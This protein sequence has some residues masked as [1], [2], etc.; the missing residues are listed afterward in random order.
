LTNCKTEEER[1]RT[2]EIIKPV[3]RGRDI[4]KW[5][6]KWADKWLIKIEAGWTN[7]NRGKQD[8]EVFFKNT[9]PSLYNHFMTFKDFKGKGKGLFDRDDQ[10]DYWWELRPCDYYPEFEKEKI[11]WEHVS[12]RYPFAY[13]DERLYLINALFMI[14]HKNNNSTELKLLMAILNSKLGDFL[15]LNFTRLSSLGRY[16]YGAKDAMEQL[17]IPPITTTNQHIVKEIENVVNQIIS[18]TQ[19]KDYETNKQKQQEVKEL[20]NQLN[21]LVYQL[22]ELTPEEIEI[23]RKSYKDKKHAT[24]RIA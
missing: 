6:Y 16:A 15:L 3:L 13:V 12:G 5:R 20:E 22:Y 7:K 11:V 23:I 17:P 8:P 2:E 21:E 18:I 9:F 14:T 19:S 4:E 24:K 1:K 10:G